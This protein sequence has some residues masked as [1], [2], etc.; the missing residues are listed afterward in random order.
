MLITLDNVAQAHQLCFDA[1]EEQDYYQRLVFA[2]IDR[3][4][5]EGWDVTKT[6]DPNLICRFWNDVWAGLPDS[7]AIRREPFN[8]ICD[9][10]EG[11][12]LEE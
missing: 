4:D 1:I 5:E 6:K 8:L 2:A 9:L 10:A 7:R 11:S 3:Y 12:Y